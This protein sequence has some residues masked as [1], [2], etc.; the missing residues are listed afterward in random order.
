ME[1]EQNEWGEQEVNTPEL[2]HPRG[3]ESVNMRI[4]PCTGITPMSG[5]TDVEESTGPFIPYQKESRWYGVLALIII[6]IILVILAL[7]ISAA[8]QRMQEGLTMVTGLT[9]AM[10]LISGDRW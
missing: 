5:I 2:Y 4:K 8:P 10:W 6:I 9:I 3:Y 7:V 1:I